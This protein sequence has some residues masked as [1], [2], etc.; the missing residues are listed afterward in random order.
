MFT[1]ASAR[2]AHVAQI[3]NARVAHVAQNVNTFDKSWPSV[4]EICVAM[5]GNAD[6]GFE[7]PQVTVR[8]NGTFLAT[9]SP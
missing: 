6:R 3:V 1:N 9:V 4:G 7:S 2:N 5:M 8:V